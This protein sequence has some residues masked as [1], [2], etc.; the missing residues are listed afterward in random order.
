LCDQ[1]VILSRMSQNQLPEMPT[2]YW[3]ALRFF[4][5]LTPLT[6]WAFACQAGQSS[7]QF[8]VLINLQNNNARIQ[9]NVCRSS[10]RIGVFGENVTVVCATGVATEFNG[11]SNNL[12]WSPVED[13]EYRFVTMAPKIADIKDENDS[14][15]GMGTVTSW[16]LVSLSNRDYLELMIGW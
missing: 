4:V 6:L 10:V 8:T 12:P 3:A 13:G 9:G 2:S 5:I 16:R 7:K 11:N 1:Q 14:Y 15:A